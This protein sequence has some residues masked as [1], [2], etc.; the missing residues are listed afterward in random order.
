M[1]SRI[2]SRLR[3]SAAE[4]PF[5]TA[6]AAP[7]RPWTPAYGP[8]HQGF[9]ASVLDD[10]A[11]VARFDGGHELPPHYGVGFDERVVEYPWVF[12]Q[13]LS[14]RVLDAGSV[15]NHAHVLDRALPAVGSLA[16]VTQRPEAASFPE[17]GVS[18]IYDDLRDLPL[19]DG[20]FDLVVCVST[21][22]HVGMDNSVYGGRDERGSDAD[23]Q[24]VA[25]VG[26]LRRVTRPGGRVLM[27]VP[28][29]R[30]E[31]HGWL[32]QLDVDDL[33]RLVAAFDARSV[34][35]SVFRYTLAGWQ[36]SSLAAASDAEYCDH[37]N[38][39]QPSADRAAAARAVACVRVEL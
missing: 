36:R 2:V 38:G 25:A 24:A 1:P 23:A 30:R 15:L 34:A 18:Y 11:L 32:R 31:D 14:G 8:A 9:V 29:G 7:A 33:Q 26:E 6:F 39:P 27:T 5:V 35:I 19:R 37:L 12:A 3:R 17:R 16:I 4:P 28:F 10:G 20:R 13:G 22:E 21:L